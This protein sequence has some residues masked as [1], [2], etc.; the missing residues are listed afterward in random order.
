MKTKEKK[1]F[2]SKPP[3]GQQIRID[4]SSAEDIECDN[5][6]SYFFEPVVLMKR[7]SALLSPTG[8]EIIIPA[9]LY[10]CA[11]CKHINKEFLEQ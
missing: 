1:M 7:L 11:D 6:G 10:R 3:N 8:E 4:A 2:N 9:Q 5:C